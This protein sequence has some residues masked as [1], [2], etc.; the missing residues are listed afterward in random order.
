M[1]ADVKLKDYY[2]SYISNAKKDIQT[3]TAELNFYRKLR[4]KQ[5]EFL[6]TNSDKYK[7]YFNINLDN[8]DTAIERA[9]LLIKDETDSNKRFYLSQLTKLKI[10]NIR[11]RE[12]S[13]MIALAYKRKSIKFRQY[14]KYVVDYY[15]KVHKFMLQGFGYTYNFGI[16]TICICRWKTSKTSKPIIDYYATNL[17]KT[18]LTKLGKKLWNKYEAEFYEAR[19]IPYDGIDYRVYRKDDH[20]YEFHIINSK[21]FSRRNHTFKHTDYVNLKFRGLSYVQMADMCKDLDEICAM[22]VDIRYKL[23]MVL[24][25]D[26]ASYILFIRNSEQDRY[27]YGAHNS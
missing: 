13:Q 10:T 2:L 26:P 21:L 7:Q 17:K 4:D 14:E 15:D 19:G 16:G 5:H 23:N 24:Y 22:S 9:E 3:Y 25:K 18:E 12:Y 1:G 8:Y 11:C 27:E 20:I 6:T